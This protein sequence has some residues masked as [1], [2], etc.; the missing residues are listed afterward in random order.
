MT[1]G[2]GSLPPRFLLSQQGFAQGGARAVPAGSGGGPAVPVPRVRDP[3]FLHHGL[4]L[5]SASKGVAL[6]EGRQYVSSRF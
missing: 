1:S 4:R 6:L 2:L 3:E 5:G